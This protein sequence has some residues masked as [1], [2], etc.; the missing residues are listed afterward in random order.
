M[1]FRMLKLS[2]AMLVLLLPV[3]SPAWA[4]GKTEITWYGQAAFKVKTPAGKVLLIDPWINNPANKTG[5]NDLAKLDR[6]DLIL[7]SHGHGDHIGNAVEIATKTRAR[8]VAPYGLSR[9]MVQYGGF[10]G[11]LAGYDT[12]GNYGGEISLLEGEVK[13]A[14]IP[15]VHDSDMTVATK[16]GPAESQVPAGNPA[17][18]LVSIKGGPVIYH[19]GDTDLFSDMALVKEF[20]PV[21]LMLV[22]IGDRFTMG[23][24]RAAEAVRLVKPKIVVPM[25]YGTFP[26]LTGTPEEFAK[27]LEKVGMGAKMKKMSVG[28]SMVW[29]KRQGPQK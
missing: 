22:C 21:D 28:E 27:D 9:A 1:I 18:F 17:G 10:P 6:V 14:F 26:F 23:P 19:T 24:K 13:V 15:A 8:L 2:C 7:I 4:E 16:G 3:S 12:M 29:K 11:E 5:K 20:H 25:H